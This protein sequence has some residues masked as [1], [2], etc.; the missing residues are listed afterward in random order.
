[1]QN[2]DKFAKEVAQGV[3]DFLEKRKKGNLLGT[4][5]ELLQENLDSEK[6]VV[7]APRL[8]KS[9]EKEKVKKFV[10]KVVGENLQDIVFV[11]DETL[12]D[13]IR[14]ETKD[15]VWDFSLSSQL[16]RFKGN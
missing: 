7:L 12:L 14:I 3:V 5:V 4:V 1:M 11:K 8:L 16:S 9:Q 15:K 2:D 10:G 13:G 6:V